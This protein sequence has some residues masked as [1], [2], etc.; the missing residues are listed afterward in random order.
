MMDEYDKCNFCK[1][2]DNYD[3]CQNWYCEGKSDYKANKQKIIE[4]AQQTGLSVADV[5]ALINMED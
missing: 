5:V 4:K 3:G 1:S 2:Y